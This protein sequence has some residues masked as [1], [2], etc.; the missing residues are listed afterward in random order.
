MAARIPCIGQVIWD[1]LEEGVELSLTGSVLSSTAIVLGF[2]LGR[3]FSECHQDRRQGWLHVVGD[4][5]SKV[6]D[7]M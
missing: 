6:R 7:Y 3:R 4:G 5:G 1:I 2:C